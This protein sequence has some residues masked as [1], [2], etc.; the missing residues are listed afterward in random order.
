M[1]VLE[2]LTLTFMTT[3]LVT[4]LYPPQ[5][6]IRVDLNGPNFKNV[7]DGEGGEGGRHDKRPQ[8]TESSSRNRFTVVLDKLEHVPGMMALTQLIHPSPSP[9]N[10]TT[11]TSDS[12]SRHSTSSSAFLPQRTSVEALRLIELS[13]RVSAVMRSSVTDTL[14]HTD[15]LLSIFK[16]F[17]QLNDINITPSMSIVKYEDMSYSVAERARNYDSDMILLPWLPPT[18]DNSEGTIYPHGPLSSDMPA[19][20]PKLQ[21]SNPFDML[22]KTMTGLDASASAIHSHFIRGVFS[23]AS[24]DVALYVDQTKPGSSVISTQHIFLPFFGGPDDRLALEFVAQICENSRITATVIRI[25][26]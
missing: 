11:P 8:N 5:F 20:T 13:D 4:W 26:K 22:F 17:G 23:Q 24:T 18:Y 10:V 9:P 14:I 16:M 6:R 25:V 3:P 15:P 1:F 7:P 19:A 12:K 21:S 2:A